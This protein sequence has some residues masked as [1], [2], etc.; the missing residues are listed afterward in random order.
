[1]RFLKKFLIVIVVLAICFVLLDR[2]AGLPNPE[3]ATVTVNGEVSMIAGPVPAGTISYRLFVLESLEGIL[4]HP[5]EEIEDFQTDTPS[6]S[7]TFEYPLHMGTG[8]AIR[9]WVDADGDGVF[10][11]PTERLDPSGLAYTTETPTGEVQLDITLTENCRAA[12]W[13]YPPA[14]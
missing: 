14:P 8:L 4:Q 6:F 11:T 1:M 13:F 12:N 5:L 3:Y 9:A 10:C 7:H 2:C